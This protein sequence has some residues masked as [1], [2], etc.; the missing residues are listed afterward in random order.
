MYL[1]A[2]TVFRIFT[3]GNVRSYVVIFNLM[4]FVV[5]TFNLLRSSLI[6]IPFVHC[7]YIHIFAQTTKN[8]LQYK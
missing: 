2:A 8:F 3:D 1:S 7:D 5:Y 4:S 6:W